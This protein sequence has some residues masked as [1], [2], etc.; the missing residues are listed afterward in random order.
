M[1]KYELLMKTKGKKPDLFSVNMDSYASSAS[2]FARFLS[3]M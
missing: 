3:T 1:L 2:N